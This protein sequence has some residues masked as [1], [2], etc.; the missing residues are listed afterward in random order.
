MLSAALFALV[1]HPVSAQTTYIWTN[2]TGGSQ[3]WSTGTNWSGGAVPN[4]VDGDTVDF[5]RVNLAA[6]AVLTLDADRRAGIWKFGDNPSGQSW[7]VNSGSTMTLDGANPTINVVNGTATLNNVPAG[8]NGFT[9]TGAGTLTITGINTFTGNVSIS[10]GTLTGLNSTTLAQAGSVVFGG[11]YQVSLDVKQKIMDR[12]HTAQT[13]A[14]QQTSPCQNP[15]EGNRI[16]F[17][18]S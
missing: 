4:P 11:G 12:S 9:K 10:A 8:T 18:K 2:T 14:D 17:S 16:D 7:T 1:H 13:P 3:S 5:S 15:R 6:N